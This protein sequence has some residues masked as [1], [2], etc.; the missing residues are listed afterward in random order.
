MRAR[1]GL[2]LGL[3]L[4]AAA[5]GGDGPIAAHDLHVEVTTGATD[6]ELGR[7]FALTVRRVWRKDLAP[8]AWED[9]ALAPLTVR[10]EQTER[11]EDGERVE[12]V[13]RFRA[14]AFETGE[15]AIAPAFVA[16]PAGGGP[17]RRAESEPVV[18]RVAPSLPPGPTGDV[19]LPGEGLRAP[20]SSL[21]LVAA[22]ALAALAAA[23]TGLLLHRR[24]RLART[25]ARAP[26]LAD[27][28]PRP[29]P[30]ERALARLAVLRRSAPATAAEVEA[31][32]AEAI[33]IARDYAGERFAIAGATRTSEEILASARR[34]VSPAA[35]AS[36]ATLLRGCDLVRFARAAS[37]APDRARLLDAAEAFVRESG[38]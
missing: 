9:D 1:A 13:R 30:A 26:A 21:A 8:S 17:D 5:C 15:L 12:E 27:D 36:L 22:I 11:R 31:F 18:L 19:E 25:S 4:A 20:P 35:Q 14:W 3:A 28:P 7:A 38:A 33:G 24:R 32:H 6:V 2:A 10:A 37:A 23:G 29:A 34:V 16:R